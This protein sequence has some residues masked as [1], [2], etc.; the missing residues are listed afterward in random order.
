MSAALS[1]LHTVG[2]RFCFTV[3]HIAKRSGK[4][5]GFN[6]IAFRFLLLLGLA[7]LGLHEAEA[8]AAW[9]LK[10][11]L[12]GLVCS[13]SGSRKCSKRNVWC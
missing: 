9:A 12:H 4:I 7:R 8:R 10:Q 6:S 11:E 2:D 5:P 1:E 13:L 3:I